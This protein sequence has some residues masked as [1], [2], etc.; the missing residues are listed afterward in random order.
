MSMFP[1]VDTPPDWHTQ[2]SCN[3]HPDPELWWYEFHKHWDENKLQ[4]LRLAEAI[5]IC[6]ECPVRAE[7]LQQGL[8]P[9]NLEHKGVW[10]GMMMS[11]RVLLKNPKHTRILNYEGRMRSQVRRKLAEQQ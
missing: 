10:G 1:E 3:G 11:E 6:N 8:E 7:C 4:V 5:S 2:A 9:A